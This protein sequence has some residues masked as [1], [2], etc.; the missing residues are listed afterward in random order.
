MTEAG[1][2]VNAD[3]IFEY[4]DATREYYEEEGLKRNR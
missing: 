1:A 4:L 2:D 3:M